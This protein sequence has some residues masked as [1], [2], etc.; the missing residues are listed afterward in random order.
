MAE[1]LEIHPDNPQPRLIRKVAEVIASGG[2]V[3]YPTDSCYAIGCALD[4]KQGIERIT[5]I[6]D[7]DSKHH[8]TLMCDDFAQ[9]GQFVIVDNSAFRTIK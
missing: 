9:L 4:N 3:A 1:I 6:R 5:R 2:L 8:F 7:L